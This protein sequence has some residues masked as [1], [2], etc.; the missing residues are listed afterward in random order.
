MEQDWT[1]IE[2]VALRKRIQNRLAQRK[3]RRKQQEQQNM[4]AAHNTQNTVNANSHSYF[5]PSFNP[6]TDQRLD[7]R[8]QVDYGLDEEEITDFGNGEYNPT[9]SGL[10]GQHWNL[11]SSSRGHGSSSGILPDLIG[12]QSE[13]WEGLQRAGNGKQQNKNPGSIGGNQHAGG[14]PIT[15]GF[16]LAPTW[17]MVQPD[18][19][20]WHQQQPQQ[21]Q[22][23]QHS[24]TPRPA[25]R[26]PE[27]L[28]PCAQK[29]QSVVS[30]L[31]VRPGDGS[32]SCPECGSQKRQKE[33]A[34]PLITTYH[35]RQGI[36]SPAPTTPTQMSGSD[37]LRDHG[38]DIA[39][40]AAQ[41]NSGRGESLSTGSSSAPYTHHH[42]HGPRQVVD[43]KRDGRHE[44]HPEQGS[45]RVTKVVVIYM[46][47]E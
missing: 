23:R 5:P 47:D 32:H 14:E 37:L 13:C 26:S 22:Q 18:N 6:Q 20:Q 10:M 45:P 17:T 8:S 31:D 12:K 46:Q 15:A 11:G 40:I 36:P 16:G 29:R 35:T 43:L 7:S 41:A 3:H 27:E 28:S 30:E 24:H 2:D 4:N 42:D 39:R 19:S 1:E 44:N 33:A 9:G 38:I 34:R 21:Q 25:G